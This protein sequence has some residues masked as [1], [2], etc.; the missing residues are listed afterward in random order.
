MEENVSKRAQKKRKYSYTIQEDSEAI[1]HIRGTTKEET[2][3]WS[4]QSSEAKQEKKHNSK[5]N[6]YEGAFINIKNRMEIFNPPSIMEP[7]EGPNDQ[8]R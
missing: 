6:R 4:V 1:S 3:D 7:E 5:Q 2:S 8:L